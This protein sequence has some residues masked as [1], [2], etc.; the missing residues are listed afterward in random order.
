[1]HTCGGGP[2]RSDV[3]S[4]PDVHNH[5]LWQRSTLHTVDAVLDELDSVIRMSQRH[6]SST[7]TCHDGALTEDLLLNNTLSTRVTFTQ[8]ARRH[9]VGRQ[10]VIQ[11]LK[12]PLVIVR[13]HEDSAPH[14][15]VLVLGD[16]ASGRALE[17]VA[18]E[19]SDG[20]VVIHAMDLRSKFRMLYEEG[21]AR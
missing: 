2:C 1:M 9:K 8:S 13:I 17:V 7:R 21:R 14:A 5:R 12:S 20:L 15:R 10:R 4:C 3:I 6:M 11:V 16:D 18:I 19:E